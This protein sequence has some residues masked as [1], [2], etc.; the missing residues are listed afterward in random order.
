MVLRGSFLIYDAQCD[1]FILHVQ[2]FM[3]G[4]YLE[5]IFKK[6]VT[7]SFFS[8]DMFILLSEMPLFMDI[9]FDLSLT[10]YE[11]VT[12]SRIAMLVIV[13]AITRS[14]PGQHHHCRFLY[15]LGFLLW[16]LIMQASIGC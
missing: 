12:A 11:V 14:I 5:F 16:F 9:C 10:P 4:C 6:H 1:V 8:H 7:K 2:N 15:C 3:V 13:T